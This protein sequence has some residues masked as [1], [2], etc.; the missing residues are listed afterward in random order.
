[1]ALE[2]KEKDGIRYVVYESIT[3]GHVYCVMEYPNGNK[4]IGEYSNDCKKQIDFRLILKNS[5]MPPLDEYVRILNKDKDL[6]E[7]SC[8]ITPPPTTD[9]K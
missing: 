7:K 4:S 6:Q 2:I 9:S 1:M 3:N 5:S 8:E